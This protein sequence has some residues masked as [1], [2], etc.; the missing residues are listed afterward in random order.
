[1]SRSWLLNTAWMLA[2]SRE[3]VRFHRATRRVAET[4]AEVLAAILRA[5]HDTQFGRDHHF[6][7]LRTPADYQRDVPPSRYED[8]DALIR[9]IT[10]GAPA[11]LT[12]EPVTLLEPTSGTTGGE[13]LIPYTASLR[14]QFQRAIAA[15]IADLF[16]ARPAVRRGRAYWSLS[17]ALGPRRR[18]AGGI[19]IGFEDDA[20]YLGVLEQMAVRRLLV[21]PPGVA[22]L[23]DLE[24]FRYLTLFCLLRAADLTLVSI[25][26]PTFLTALFSRFEEWQ[27]RLCADIALGSPRPPVPLCDRLAPRWKPD[28]NRAAALA[29]IFRSGAATPEKLRRAWPG[30]SLISCWAD[31]GAARFLP[32]LRSLFP[33]V[34][35]QPKGLLA[36]EG[37]VSLPLVGREGAA[38]AIRSHFFEFEETESPDGCFRLAHELDRGGR[39]WV[40]LTTGG[41][42]YRYQLR[43]EVEV[44][45]F[46]RRCPLLRFLGKSDRVS[47]LVGE[48]LAE[49][50]VQTVLDRL[51]AAARQQPSFALLVP[52]LGR[53]PRYRLYVQ[54]PVCDPARLT[55]GIQTGLEENPY[56][57]HAVAFGQLAPAELCVLGSDG[58]P[59]WS[60]Y[61]RQRLQRG[62]RCGAI[63]P[64]ALDAWTGWPELFE[65]AARPS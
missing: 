24:A 46:F 18:T 14:K 33:G 49:A 54:G 58:P 43:D 38:L 44:V 13:K 52:V 35:V 60:I 19:P 65:A 5:N 55:A 16:R 61:E 57:R 21:V 23:A 20:A 6:A 8:F 25:W 47:D 40:V 30:L 28:A 12:R 31:A 9:R 17:P 26:N 32:E 50:H 53:P 45:G 1:M 3:A 29:S 36:T 62:Q 56:Y 39:Y 37:V 11:V 41:G 34:E 10:D 42:L 7:R 48:K 2:C 15:W 22:R 51:F 64:A 63:K 59:A 4:Q 27:D